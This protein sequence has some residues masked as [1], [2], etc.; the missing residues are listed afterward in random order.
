MFAPEE[1]KSTISMPADHAP[2]HDAPCRHLHSESQT[3]WI[4]GLVGFSLNSTPSISEKQVVAWFIRPHYPFP[5]LRCPVSSFPTPL[6]TNFGVIS[7]NKWCS[8]RYSTM[9]FYPLQFSAHSWIWNLLGRALVENLCQLNNSRVPVLPCNSSETTLIMLL[10][11]Y[12]R[13]AVTSSREG[14]WILIPTF[15]NLW[16]GC[17]WEPSEVYRLNGHQQ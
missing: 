6:Q 3:R 15:E 16:Y 10:K 17:F 1:H 2:Y 4:H 14:L 9:H 12:A 11:N 13:T 7:R 5:I 8:H